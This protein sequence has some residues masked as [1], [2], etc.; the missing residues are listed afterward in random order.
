MDLE[1]IKFETTKLSIENQ[2]LLVTA[3]ETLI[4]KGIS[5]IKAQAFQRYFLDN[6]QGCRPHCNHTKYVRFGIDKAAQRYKYKSCGRS[7]TKYTTAWMASLHKKDKIFH[8]KHINSTHNSLKKWIDNAYLG[9][10]TKYLQQH[11]N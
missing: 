1:T 11:L 7:F 4:M 6:K 10:A 9:V 3:L 5:T 2:D 8:I